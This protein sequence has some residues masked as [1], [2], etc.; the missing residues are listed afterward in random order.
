MLI[1][2]QRH[3]LWRPNHESVLWLVRGKYKNLWVSTG[4]SYA[5]DS[6]SAFT[7][8]KAALGH[9]TSD[10]AYKQCLHL[11][12]DAHSHQSATFIILMFCYFIVFFN[13]PLHQMLEMPTVLSYACFTSLD[14]AYRKNE[15]IKNSGIYCAGKVSGSRKRGRPRLRWIDKF[16][17]FDLITGE[18][19]WFTNGRKRCWIEMIGYLS[20]RKQWLELSAVKLQGRERYHLGLHQKILKE[21][22]LCCVSF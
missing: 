9:R 16:N 11:R 17:S 15:W 7:A 8:R 13:L 5:T 6:T 12:H 1:I 10:R 14:E 20:L 22:Y 18:N 19:V 4:L 2:S 21:C 3:G